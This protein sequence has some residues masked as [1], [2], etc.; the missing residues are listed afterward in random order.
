[1]VVSPI[2]TPVPMIDEEA[3]SNLHAGMNIDA[4]LTVRVLTH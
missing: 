2:T 3:F 1:M 4:S